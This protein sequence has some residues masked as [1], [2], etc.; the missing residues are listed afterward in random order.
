MK[1][2]CL[3][4]VNLNAK[5]LL[6]KS[7][8]PLL[9]GLILCS[10]FTPQLLATHIV[11]G[12]MTYRCL[13]NDNYE[14]R[15][16]IFRDCFNGSPNA[17][18]DDP[19][20]IGIYDFEGTLL[21]SLFIPFIET[22]DDTLN[23]I[24]SDP[25]LVVPPNVCVHTTFYLDT[26]QLPVIPGGYELRYQRCCRNVTIVN[27]I[28]PLGT[29][30]TF[31]VTLSETALQ[32]CNSSATFLQWPPIYICV[33]E[34]I[35]F[36]QSAIDIDGDSIVYRLCTPLDGAT[37]EEPEP[38]P[39]LHTT[40]EE[41]VWID[42][43]YN[44]DNVLGGIPLAINEQTGLLTG[45]PSTVGQFVV[46]I[47]LEEY[48]DG[49]LISTT[50]RDF[51]YNVGVCGVALSSFFAPEI[52]CEGLEVNFINQSSNADDFEW[53]FNDPGNPGAF[54]DEFSPTYTFSDTGA[55][56][57]LL[58]AEPGGEC[59][60][61]FEQEIY[62]QYPSL[63]A[64][65]DFNYVNCTD[66]LIIQVN[67]LTIDTISEP[68]I[69]VWT[70]RD[71]D[72][73]VIGTSNEQNPSFAITTSTEV[74]LELVVTAAN[75]CQQT[76][77]EVFPANVFN[78][79]SFP[80]VITSCFD[81]A[82]PLNPDPLP[83]VSYTWTP[84]TG[85]DNPT[86]PTPIASP[87]ETT[88][89]VVFIQSFGNCQLFDT[90]TVVVDSLAADFTYEAPC[91]QEV[92]FFNDSYNA[93]SFA[94]YFNDPA[95]P[96]SF[97]FLENPTYTY[98]DSGSYSVLLVADNGPYCLDSI[99]QDIDVGATALMPD[100]TFEFEGCSDSILIEV[101]D[102]SSHAD[103]LDFTWDWTLSD[104]DGEVLGTSNAQNPDFTV[105]SSN[106]LDLSLTITD[107]EG[108]DWTYVET[109]PINIFSTDLIPDASLLCPNDTTQ[110]N[111]NPLPGVTYSWSPATDL[112]D[113][114]ATSPLAFPDQAMTYF[115]VLE[116]AFGCSYN[117]TVQVTVGDYIP[118]VDAF[119][120]PDTIFQGDTTQLF[121]TIEPG[122]Q[123]FWDPTESLNDPNIAEPFAFPD[124]TTAYTLEIIDSEG[125]NNEVQLSVV[126]V[127]PICEEPFVFFPNAFTPNNDGE[128]DIIQVFGNHIE[129]MELVI[130][131]RWGQKVFESTDPQVG[132][133]GTFEGETLEPDAYG[134]YLYVL[135]VGGEE[136]YKQG[137]IMLLK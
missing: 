98:A 64:D 86:S 121:G 95:N 106:I 92:S 119:A 20:K 55:Y 40:P 38:I 29:G 4:L 112:S 14:I 88:T 89:Y 37:P 126:V 100:F 21:D 49:N 123:Y 133:D 10:V 8:R 91:D 50:R 12:E 5:I 23:P 45:T 57:V 97:S 63:F 128:N 35:N 44:L 105:Y 69:W 15:L 18:F 118:F 116:D 85:L 56:T 78:E 107:T 134:F 84:S 137:N 131:N 93:E 120:D 28:D 132:W 76:L 2:D 17:Y 54:S 70:L 13:G 43:P 42:P 81:T 24:L 62:L 41:V 122:Y 82:V 111:P 125:C 79:D 117:D 27:I 94:W 68:E 11:G 66:S 113:A 22:Q 103:S 32:E 115:V 124:E 34:P 130:Y 30:A 58:V 72:G 75:G 47:C 108:C 9:L 16:T 65:F 99:I 51:Q 59:V 110:L 26:V 25:C 77:V 7:L 39:S 129:V 90:V 46:G 101:T 136:Y 73:I 31:G 61:S 19:A 104:M 48:R 96:T 109:F 87:D 52:Y 83:G 74:T 102:F 127:E 36:D 33:N 71:A 114:S 53:Y 135:C 60:D 3:F 1:W 80:D 67:D 6:K